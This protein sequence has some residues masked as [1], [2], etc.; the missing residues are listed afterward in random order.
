MD[1]IEVYEN[2]T[3]IGTLKIY[4]DTYFTFSY[5]ENYQGFS[6]DPQLPLN[7][8]T[9]IYENNHLWGCF[10]DISPDRWGRVLQ[11][12]NKGRLLSDYEYMLGVSDYYRMGSLRL[13]KNNDFIAKTHNIPKL[14]NIN[15]LMQSSLNVEKEDYKKSDLDLLLEPSSSLGG[16]RIKASVLDKD[17]TL[18][19]AKFP[20]SND[21]YSVILW[22]KT[23][24]DLAKLAKIEVANAKL[25]VAKNNKKVLLLERFDRLGETRIPFMSA[26]TL[27]NVS[28]RNGAEN[29]SYVELAKK[30]T[31]NEKQKL[32]RRMVFNGLFG[33]T[34]D[35]LRNHAILYH[36]E[37]KEWKL[38]PAFDVNPNPI[39]Y[40]KQRH[41]LNFIDSNNLPSIELFS[42]LKEFFSVS[43]ELWNEILQDCLQVSKNFRQFAKNN[44]ITNA[45]INF[46]SQNFTNE[47]IE[48]IEK[49][50]KPNGKKL[51]KKNKD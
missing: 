23:M 20:S 33:N 49:I 32:F 13:K 22:E 37:T 29:Q 43:S 34:D 51:H 44:G 16:A 17:N 39:A 35:H 50:L 26:M 31:E 19:L 14:V 8:K 1:S 7:D 21:E 9:I 2:T 41:A 48:K 3:H 5:K 42:N 12:R 11:S 6:I 18:C 45:E 4:G 40:Q 24:L 47:D 25:I 27:L 28:E 38:S 46:I 10:K 36:R 15:E 30:L